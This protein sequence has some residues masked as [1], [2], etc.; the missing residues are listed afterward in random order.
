MVSP[1]AS[2]V[3]IGEADLDDQLAE[4]ISITPI[5]GGREGRYMSHVDTERPQIDCVALVDYTDPSSADI[6]KLDARIP[7]QELEAQIRRAV[8]PPGAKLRKGDIVQ[9]LDRPGSPRTK[10][11]RVDTDD[12][13]RLLVTLAPIQDEDA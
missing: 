8:L 12:P 6:A 13:E 11:G 2:E 1:F 7:Y 10:I 3:A 4:N 5:R 9:L